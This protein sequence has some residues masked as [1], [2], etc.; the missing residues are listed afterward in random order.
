MKMDWEQYRARYARERRPVLERF[1]TRLLEGAVM[2]TPHSASGYAG[3][4]TAALITIFRQM[5]DLLQDSRLPETPD[6]RNRV[7]HILKERYFIRLSGID[8]F[9]I[10]EEYVRTHFRY[11]APCPEE[12]EE[13]LRSFRGHN[14]EAEHLV[15][16]ID[17]ETDAF[18]M[19]EMPGI[20]KE[21]AQRE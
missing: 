12:T 13:W 1:R 10:A 9:V 21:Q 5:T 19:E 14:T 4:L 2:A 18:I 8:R 17:E 15:R 6:S 11:Q 16:R 7:R 20:L 3:A